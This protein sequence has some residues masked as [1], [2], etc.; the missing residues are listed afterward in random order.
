MAKTSTL[1]DT[2]QL[3]YSLKGLILRDWNVRILIKYN[4]LNSFSR[5]FSQFYWISSRKQGF[6]LHILIGQQLHEKDHVAPSCGVCVRPNV[7][8]KGGSAPP[9]LVQRLLLEE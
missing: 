3:K 7:T 1:Y 9:K 2:S 4:E 8:E 6:Y 5:N